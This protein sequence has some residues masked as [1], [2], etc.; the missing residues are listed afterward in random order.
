MDS[1]IIILDWN[2]ISYKKWGVDYSNKHWLQLQH[3]CNRH[4]QET[5]LLFI[6]SFIPTCFSNMMYMNKTLLLI[7]T[8]PWSVY[9]VFS[10]YLRNVNSKNIETQ[11]APFETIYNKDE[12]GEIFDTHQCSYIEKS[13][14]K[15]M[16]RLKLKFDRGKKKFQ[17]KYQ[18]L[19]HRRNKYLK[20][21][22]A[23]KAESHHLFDY[24][25]DYNKLKKSY[26]HTNVHSRKVRYQRSLLK[27]QPI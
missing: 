19:Y 5:I 21:Y 6:D 20:P 3:C 17:N 24:N 22:Y 8:Y 14:Q 10:I 11:Q 27:L 15:Y 12:C 16:E 1:C 25:I 26:K 23:P 7:V 18:D 13:M 4:F 9:L 2:K